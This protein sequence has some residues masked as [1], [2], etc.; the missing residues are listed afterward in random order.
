MNKWQIATGHWYLARRTGG[1]RSGAHTEFGKET[2]GKPRVRWI[3]HTEQIRKTQWRCLTSSRMA[4]FM[5]AAVRYTAVCCRAQRSH[6]L[7]L[8]G[9]GFKSCLLLERKT[10]RTAIWAEEWGAGFVYRTIC[11]ESH[12]FRGNCENK[13]DLQH[14]VARTERRH[15]HFGATIA[16][17]GFI[18][19]ETS[20]G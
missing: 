12:S 7:T 18:H 13:T 9:S 3:V 6:L 5:S 2:H 1:I 19:V 10:F 20:S 4:V 17:P 8:P 11:Y 16:F 15:H 14:A